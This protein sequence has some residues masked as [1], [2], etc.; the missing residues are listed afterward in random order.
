V[1]GDGDSLSIGGNHLLHVIRRNL[2]VKILLFNNRIYGLTKGQYSPTSERGTL[3]KSSPM[4]SLEAPVRPLSFALGCGATFAARALAVDLKHLEYVLERAAKHKGTALVEIY[5]NCVIFNGGVFDYATDKDAKP[6][7]TLYLEHGKPLTF[8]K[9][10]DK[11]IRVRNL[12]PEVFTLADSNA[13]EA[14]IHDEREARPV[15]SFM[16]SN[17]MQPEFPEPFGVFRAVERETFE[18][19]SHEQSR[20][21]RVQRGKFDLQDLLNGKETWTVH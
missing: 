14:I 10:G 6:D 4:G 18:V 1:T 20:L 11:S 16:L 12:Q 5:Q 21:A 13:S 19:A 17:L 9:S 7:N 15:L 8:G 3:T 2:N